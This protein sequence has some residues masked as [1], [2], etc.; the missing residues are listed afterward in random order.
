MQKPGE[1]VQF[2]TSILN[3]RADGRTIREARF[4]HGKVKTATLDLGRVDDS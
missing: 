2:E 4:K 3:C 1:V